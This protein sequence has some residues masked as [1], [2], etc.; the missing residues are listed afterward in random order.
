MNVL[1]F[2]LAGSLTIIEVSDSCMCNMYTVASRDEVKAVG[3]LLIDNCREIWKLQDIVSV[4]CCSLQAYS[5]HEMGAG[6]ILCLVR[7]V[8]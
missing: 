7:L 1:H 8:Y 2:E 5:Q 6:A 3:R 4:T